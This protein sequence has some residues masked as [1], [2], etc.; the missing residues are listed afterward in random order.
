MGICLQLQKKEGEKKRQSMEWSQMVIK[1]PSANIHYQ[2]SLGGMI[3]T[4]N[5]TVSCKCLQKSGIHEFKFDAAI[6]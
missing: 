5:N 3:R 2:I 4:C 6:K 1:D